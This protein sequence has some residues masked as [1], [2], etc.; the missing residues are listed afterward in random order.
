MCRRAASAS[1]PT[2]MRSRPT[3]PSRPLRPTRTT[4]RPIPGAP[5]GERRRGRLSPV[6]AADRNRSTSCGTLLH[7]RTTRTMGRGSTRARIK[8]MALELFTKQGYEG[9]SL[10]EIAE[11]LGV[12][13]AAVYCHFKTKEGIL[14]ELLQE[15]TQP[16]E[17]VI[18]WAEAQPLRPD[19]QQEALRRYEGA[20]AHAA[21]IFTILREPGK[22][23]RPRGRGLVPRAVDADIGPVPASRSR[24]GRPGPCRHRSDRRT[25]SRWSA[26]GRRRHCGR[27]TG[28]CSDRRT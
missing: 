26:V 2:R 12:T 1:I 21:P 28:C 8:E 3:P 20:L 25:H 17:D 22:P 10:R 14:A 4:D 15:R 7:G 6:R 16:I 19:V 13:K 11:H 23:A 18:A 27:E 24:P 9:T 5:Y